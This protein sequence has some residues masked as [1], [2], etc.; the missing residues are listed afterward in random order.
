MNFI[1]IYRTFDW[2]TVSERIQCI[3]ELEV[4]ACL[5]KARL[6]WQDAAVLL[7]PA[8]RSYLED[9]ARRAHSITAQRFGKVIQMY[10]PMYL[11]NECNNICTYCGFSFN[12][13]IRRH[14]LTVEEAARESRILHRMGFRH[15][16]LLTGEEIRRV[17]VDYLEAVVRKIRPYFHSVS[18]EVQPLSIEQYKRLIEAGVDGLTVYQETYNPETYRQVH[19]KGRKRNFEWRLETAERGARAKMRRVNIGALLGLSDDWR[20]EGFYIAAHAAHL[21]R[22]YWQSQI[23]ISFPRIRPAEGEYQLR[24][25]VTDSALVQ[26]IC[27]MR[28][29]F[30]DAGL[31]LSTRESAI[32]RD[33]LIPLGITQMS[34]GSRTNPGGYTAEERSGEQFAIDDSRSPEEVARVILQH[35]YEPVWKDWDRDFVPQAFTQ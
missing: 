17:G 1:D 35:G 21:L 29:L 16:L 8:A 15:I 20:T 31:V 4:E 33:R 10:A 24:K 6:S 11:S 5:S 18:I 19:L 25:R 26:L 32:L 7:S 23:L 27:G 3:T 2:R 9:I 34:A 22:H 14:T 28:L 13:T 12:N 30:P